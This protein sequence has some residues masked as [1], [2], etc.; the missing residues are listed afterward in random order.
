MCISYA[1]TTKKIKIKM[2]MLYPCVTGS[3]FTSTLSVIS[4]FSRSHDE[5][6]SVQKLYVFEVF[7]ASLIVAKVVKMGCRLLDFTRYGDQFMKRS[8]VDILLNC[9]I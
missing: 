5:F 7:D 2:L 4:M 6:G 9:I 3:S 1:T 8:N